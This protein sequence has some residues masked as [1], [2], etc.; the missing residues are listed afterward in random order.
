[1]TQ[2]LSALRR[3]TTCALPTRGSFFAIA[4]VSDRIR[5]GVVASTKGQWP[6][7]SKEGATV[8]ATVDDRDSDMGSGAV[9][10]DNRV[11]VD[12][13]REKSI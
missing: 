11:R 10:H 9:Y 8:N 1:M 2:R 6:S 4:D 5:P 3:E 7:N 12:R 13:I